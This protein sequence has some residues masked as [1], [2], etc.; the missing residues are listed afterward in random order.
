MKSHR[1][2]RDLAAEI[3][4]H[5]AERAE[6][7]MEGGMRELE[8]RQQARREFGNPTLYAEMGGENW[9]WPWLERTLKDLRYAVR[10][11]RASPLFTVTAVLSL[12][13]GIGA[14]TAVF[15]LLYASL[16]KPLPVPAPHQIFQLRRYAENGPWNGESSYSY[17]LFA[18]LRAAGPGMGEVF[19]TE[20]FGSRKFG[21]NGV[22]NERI[23][24]E[25][26]TVNFF[27]TLG[28]KPY[29]GRLFEPQDDS[30][31]G[32][33]H[34]AILSHAFWARRFRSNPAVLGKTIF[35]DETPYTVVGVAQ[36]G[37][38]GVDAATSL[39]V[40]VPVTSCVDKAWL[41][42]PNVQWLRLMVRLH[43]GV[44]PARAQALFENT[45]RMHV[46]EKLLPDADPHWRPT[47]EAQHL[48][49]RTA[50]G[51]MATTGH[52]YEKPLL[53]LMAVVGTVLLISCGNVANLIL[54]R[55]S[56]RQHEITIR[57]ALG[58]S[59]GRI[60]G[61]L[62]S[63]SLLLA[64]AGAA[65]A[66][67]M[68]VWGTQLLISF[69]PQPE[70]PLA[71][72]LRPGFAVLGFTAAM[73]V[74]T[75][76][77]FGMAPAW[78]AGRGGAEL[79]LRTAQRVTRTS[80]SGRLLVAGQLALSLTLLIGAGL[81]VTTLRNLNAAD[82]GFRADN[83]VVVDLSFPKGTAGD[84]LRQTYAQI[85]ER[86]ESDPGVIAASYAWP[87]IYGRGGWSGGIQIEGRPAAPGE[88]NDVGMIST[89]PGFFEAIGM[90]LLEGRYLN[91]QDQADKPPVA[92]VNK[93]LARHY[94]GAGA[95]IGHRIQM[96]GT[97]D[98]PKLVREIVGVVGDARHYGVREKVMR[99]IYTPTWNPQG[100]SIFVRVQAGT[101]ALNGT[102]RAVVAA[103]DKSAQIEG[104]NPL[105]T[106]VDDMIS[107]ERLTATLC[108]ALGA[109]AVALAAIGLYG[110]VGYSVS[111]RT[112]EFG[113]R[114]ALGAQR[115]DVARLVIRQTVVFVVAGV[116]AGLAA[117]LALA[118]IF[119]KAIAGMLYGVGPEDGLIFAAAALLLAA[120]ALIA[121]L[122]PA[123]RASRID[124]TIALR[125]E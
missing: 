45:F 74:A 8:A 60:A 111:R 32:G 41:T 96:S 43:P 59:R 116:S 77:L 124:P 71:F 64:A 102:I 54:A 79:S 3:E 83:V 37:F 114:M 108:A 92:V 66:L 113:I 9:G 81:F 110:V 78:R 6:E 57:L 99:M 12:A 19:A 52:K 33:N 13:L 47:L 86:L 123:R 34:V 39:D 28:V 109:L 27:S 67:A 26:V 7:L 84:R 44:S 65:C 105:K 106:Q 2:R 30:V 18:K 91:A 88:D 97:P 120:V 62:F 46:A 55:N 69:L 35:Y 103:T 68:A 89:G 75:A 11:L 40:W 94:F 80:L 93:S 85:K 50:A 31:L 76:I 104:I 121:A 48:T 17:V 70:V 87:G 95:A 38:T 53:L 98:R 107:E 16:W 90:R 22:S 115:G 36:A 112:N 1:M 20:L 117:A 51:G 10:S 101:P 72:D 15:T 58:A 122:L 82:L 24:G 29:L 4:A 61:Q 118:H 23:S 56:A 42:E 63:E 73:A 100:G 49:L 21:V 125:Y 5:I 14:N 119:S 25:A